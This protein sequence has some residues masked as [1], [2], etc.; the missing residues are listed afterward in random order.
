MKNRWVIYPQ[1][2]LTCN[3]CDGIIRVKTNLPDSMIDKGL[4]QD[5]D[6]VECTEGCEEKMHISCDADGDPAWVSDC[7]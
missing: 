3:H 5:G 1:N 7:D 2:T 6:K 4:Y